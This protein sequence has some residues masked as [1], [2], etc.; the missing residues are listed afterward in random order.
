MST[1]CCAVGVVI[2]YFQRSRG[3][4][5]RALRSVAV[6]RNAGVVRVIVVDDDS[7]VS[8]E[9]EIADL[10]RDFPFSLQVIRQRNAGPGA[11]RN[12]GIAELGPDVRYIAFLDSDDEWSADHLER[13]LFALSRGFDVYFADFRHPGVAIT[14]F[15]RAGRIAPEKHEVLAGMPNLHGY[16]GDMLAQ[17]LTGNVIGTSTVVYDRQRFPDVAFRTAYRNA[18]EDY[19]FWIDLVRAGARFAFSSECAV[20][21]GFGVNVYTGAGWGT[22]THFLRLHNEI[23]YRKA[24]LNELSLSNEVGTKVRADVA[25]LRNAMVRDLLHRAIHRKPLPLAWAK[26]HARTDPWTYLMLPWIL[27]VLTSR[28]L[29]GM[30]AVPRALGG[31]PKSEPEG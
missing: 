16:H 15:R 5:A 9:R 14:A 2:P 1:E 7:P 12:L 22:E 24:A 23:K 11:A 6:Q 4:L 13:A 10:D 20:T 28:K 21:Y 3:V 8:A 25:R 27:C 17:V 29:S 31:R 18:G 19:L 26:D 30:F